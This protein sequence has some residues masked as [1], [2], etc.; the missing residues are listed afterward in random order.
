MKVIQING[1]GYDGSTGKI[2]RQLS[3]MMNQKGVENKIICSGYKK[4]SFDDKT[5]AISGRIRVKLHQIIGYFFGDAGFHSSFSTHKAIKILKKEKP[6]IVHLHHLEGYFIHVGMLLRYLRKSG[7]KTVWTMHDCWPFTGFC[8][9]FDSIG[10]TKYQTE[11]NN[12]TQ[13]HKYPYSLFWDKSRTLYRKKKS[14]T[15][16][17]PNL[18]IVNVS[19]WM[20][21]ITKCSFLKANDSTVIYNGINTDLFSPKPET[22]IRRK[23]D[24]QN[25]F[26]ILGVASKWTNQKGFND[27]L[28]LAKVIHDDTVIILVG[29]DNDQLSLLPPNIIGVTRTKNQAEL[30]DYYCSADVLVNL[31]KEETMGLV[32]V[33]AMSCGTPVIVCPTTASPELVPKECGVVLESADANDVVSALHIVRQNKKDFYVDSCRRHVLNNFTEQKM[34]DEYYN[35]YNRLMRS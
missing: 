25:K 29:L 5:I 28:E 14:L 31:S 12:C 8:T 1:N 9:H 19:K 30:R 16:A 2:V 3:N 7:I 34:C 11:C 10:C 23:H 18:H 17:L 32:T 15:T 35:L 27:F 20:D 13:L 21:G 22:D 24:I 4:R 26:I 6:D 33:E